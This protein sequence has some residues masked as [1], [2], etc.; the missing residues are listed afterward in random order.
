MNVFRTAKISALP[1]KVTHY[2]DIG[3]EMKMKG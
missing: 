2:Y 1:L 3:R